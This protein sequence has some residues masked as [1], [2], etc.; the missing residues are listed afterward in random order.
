M[1]K[2]GSCEAQEN[3]KAFIRKKTQGHFWYLQILLGAPTKM[4][5]APHSTHLILV[6]L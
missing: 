5:G 3:K 2:N 1:N 4:L 6:I